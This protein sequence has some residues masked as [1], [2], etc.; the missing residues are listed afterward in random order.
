MQN[1]AQLNLIF[2]D[3]DLYKD[4]VIPSKATRG[5]GPLVISLL[6][7]YY[8]NDVVRDMIDG[9]S[10]DQIRRGETLTNDFIDKDQKERFEN[11]R[12]LFSEMDF[13]IAD[14]QRQ[15]LDG[16]DSFRGVAGGS[17]DVSEG[18]G[19]GLDAKLDKILLMLSSL[20]AGVENR[21]ASLVLPGVVKE[22]KVE[23]EIIQESVIA[24]EA[25]I[26]TGVGEVVDGMVST[27]LNTDMLKSLGF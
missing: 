13:S 2:T 1:R 10:L 17:K 19:N 22:S 26:D 9:Y 7:L 5:L 11:I 14:A 3:S 25:E 18:S 20:V 16:V 8:Y 15:V 12:M 23:D 21:G 24:P 4:L 6:T 27:S